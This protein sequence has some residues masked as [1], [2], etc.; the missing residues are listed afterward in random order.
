MQINFKI[1]HLESVDSTSNYVATAFAQG[2]SG[3]GSVILADKQTSGR[4]QRDSTWHSEGGL[5][6]LFSILLIPDNMSASQSQSMMHCATLAL[7]EVLKSFDVQA[8]IKWPN[9]VVVGRQKIAGILI[10]NQLSGTRISRSI[11]GI[12]LN[13]NQ[14]D[15][16]GLNATSLYLETGKY[17][18]V[19]DVLLRFLHHF[20]R[21]W[22]TLIRGEFQVLK[23]V[24]SSLL[25]GLNETLIFE[26]ELG[27][28]Q[29]LIQGVD[30]LGRLH[31]L[32]DRGERTYDLKE[33]RFK[34]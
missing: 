12:G 26:D 22:S 31:V 18:D 24:Y 17:A 16:G 34:L 25:F 27:E 2:K 3:H 6:L 29:G 9:D 32:S 30:E 11:L 20:D 5:N 13:I 14:S 21:L 15:F 7:V 33:I 1:T 23:S 10:E 19:K 28:F 4:G 8:L